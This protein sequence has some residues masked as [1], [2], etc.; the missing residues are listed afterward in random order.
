MTYIVITDSKVKILMGLRQKPMHG[1]A[2]SQELR[3]PLTSVYEHL[4]DLRRN[5]FIKT[6]GA[7]RRKVYRLTEKGALLLRAVE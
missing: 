6:E 2:M 7:G 5:G 1:Y 4:R 3:V